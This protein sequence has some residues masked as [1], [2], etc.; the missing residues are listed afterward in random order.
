[1]ERIGT[2]HET[3]VDDVSI[4]WGE[5]DS[6][7]PLLLLHGL[8]DS[9]RTW[10]RVAPLLAEHFRVQMPDLPGHGY[11]GR[12][13]ACYTLEWHSA[14]VATWM[15]TLGIE[16]AHVCG[17]SYGGGVAQ[18]M[19]LMPAIALFWGSKDPFIPIRHGR[20]TVAHS[21]G[22][23][24]TTY[25]NCGYYAQLEVPDQFAS[26]LIAFLLDPQRR[27]ARF[28]KSPSISRRATRFGKKHLSEEHRR[29]L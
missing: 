11:S 13:G 17:H 22:I 15:D 16:C 6:G 26:D 3:I 8:Y 1:M 14:M 12:S 4:A 18:R 29:Q 28:P 24:L 27:S 20:K 9:H 5:M 25:P 2:A 10:R 7:Y 21:E 19:F 23:T